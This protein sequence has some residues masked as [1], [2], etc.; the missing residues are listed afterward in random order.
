VIESP[1]G[2][3]S[4][5]STVMSDVTRILGKIE[6]GDPVAADELL[7]LVYE[8]L[9][10]LAAAKMAQEKPDQTLQ[11]TALVHEAYIRLVDQDMIQRW[12]SRGHFFAAAAEAMRRILVEHARRRR[13]VKHG[14]ELKRADLCHD[15]AAIESPTDDILALDEA[16]TKLEAEFP[17]KAGLVKLRFFAGMST[18]EA[19]RAL[20]ISLATAER[21][22]TYS[23][24]WL[25]AEL[26]GGEKSET[27]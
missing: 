15:V 26:T 18:P 20:G 9:R 7:P 14:G 6:S 17:V 13:R 16:L 25:H 24:C 8:E 23:R 1:T 11:A 22:W 21:Y 10:K 19:A 4:L 3:F 2:G 5:E 12:D 27:G